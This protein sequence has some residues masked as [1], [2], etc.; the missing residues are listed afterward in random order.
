MDDLE[1]NSVDMIFTSPDPLFDTKMRKDLDI[2]MDKAWTV[3]KPTGSLWLHLG[4]Y[5]N[6]KG[7]MMLLPETFMTKWSQSNWILRNK[8]VWHRIEDSP[9][10]ESNRFRR[11]WEYL[12]MYTKQ[13]EG[14]YFNWIEG[15]Q[16]L[17][18][19]LEYPYSYT[20]EKDIDSGFPRDLIRR[21]IWHSCPKGGVVLDPFC[22][23]GIT[24]MVA[25]KMGCNFI[26]IEIRS[27]DIPKIHQRLNLISND[28][29][30]TDPL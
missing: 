28:L 29:L 19:V 17:S 25:L 21:A 10:E 2:V 26:G 15:I 13:K 14:Y 16:K 24:G 30:K 8:L 12:L 11:N 5:H 27:E 20:N 1:P 7:S 23:S 22:G 4:D 9:M 3:L 18:S 6:D